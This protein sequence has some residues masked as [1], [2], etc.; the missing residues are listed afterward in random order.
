MVLR[1]K[2]NA[3]EEKNQPD[4]K[5]KNIGKHW[6]VNYLLQFNLKIRCQKTMERLG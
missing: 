4:D 5:E 6:F 3:K 2:I 1:V